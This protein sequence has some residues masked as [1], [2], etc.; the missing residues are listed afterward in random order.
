VKLQTTIIRLRTNINLQKGCMNLMSAPR[1]GWNR[2]KAHNLR[3][4][5]II[6]RNA[7]GYFTLFRNKG[8]TVILLSFAL[9][10]VAQA[11][12]PQQKPFSLQVSAR[13]VVLDVVVTDKKGVPV[14]NLKQDDFT[15]YEDG[16]EQRIR[17]F[18]APSS[19]VLPSTGKILVSSTADLPKIGN[20]P[21]TLLVLDELNTSFEDMAYARNRVEKYLL[22]QP[23]ILTQPTTLI[24]A[25]NT[26]FDVIADYTQDRALLLE[27]LHKHFPEYPWKMMKSG[28][29]SAGAF[30]RMSQ[31]LNSLYEIAE[32]SSGT[33]G[34]KTVIW[35]GKG[36]PTV[37]LT[38]LDINSESR[39][40]IAIRR[41]T[42][43]M[44]TSRIT[45]YTVD[46][47]SSVKT[48]AISSISTP[49]DLIDFE[50]NNDGEPF[51]DSI[52][53]STLAPVTGGQAFLG[54]NDIDAEVATSASNG[55]SYYTLSYSP[56]NKST[57]AEK[58][59]H[60]RI[61]LTNP[62]LI[63]VTRDGYDPQATDDAP[64]SL[65]GKP[66]SVVR[67]ELEAQMGKAAISSMTYNGLAI[68]MERSG[69]TALKF[70]IVAG[71]LQWEDIGSAQS[72]AEIT[73]LQVAFSSKGKALA[74][75]S[76]EL[77]ATIQ[78]RLENSSQK[79][80]FTIPLQ[81][82]PGTMRLRLVV[83]DAHTGKIGTADLRL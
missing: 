7:L 45:L 44:L 36:F 16:V 11:Q 32:A 79:V 21:V 34:R 75:S 69:A 67:E 17:S 52:S 1:P 29:N 30:E 25:T 10:V 80:G 72:R 12:S 43:S 83:R 60:I 8:I 40:Q 50:G 4:L 76:Q 20:A 49:E 55:A 9:A 39:M 74:H 57:N 2:F 26:R 63:A 51:D 5:M 23:S 19:H 13:L 56:S 78:G 38:T 66:K 27:K 22:A 24:V 18:A 47:E 59:R 42:Q 14:T 53:F 48:P 35:V 31:S 33:P 15:I 73:V 70:N 77:Q 46:P 81:I 61:K 82:P 54:R 65:A 68:S 58:Y 41:L 37:N 3:I 64:D 6:S 62:N 71:G 28:A